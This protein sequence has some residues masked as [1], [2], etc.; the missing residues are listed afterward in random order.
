[1]SQLTVSAC[2]ESKSFVQIEKGERA[3]AAVHTQ[4]FE[5]E[6]YIFGFSFD[7]WQRHGTIVTITTTLHWGKTLFFFDLSLSN[8]VQSK[9]WDEQLNMLEREREREREK[10]RQH[11]EKQSGAVNIVHIFPTRTQWLSHWHR[12]TRSNR[13]QNLET[14]SFL[15]S[16]LRRERKWE[17]EKVKSQW[18][19]RHIT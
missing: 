6:K 18:G 2:W 17:R 8:P 15:L 16:L 1:M 10:E 5:V 7:Q 4:A 9:G 12:R 3:A 19:I 11:A 14:F 13:I